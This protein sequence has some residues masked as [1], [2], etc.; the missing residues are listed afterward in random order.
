M[1]GAGKRSIKESCCAFIA[2]VIVVTRCLLPSC[3]FYLP[4]LCARPILPLAWT[5]AKGSQLV[6]LPGPTPSF[7]PAPNRGLSETP[8]TDT[9][10]KSGIFKGSP[11]PFYSWKSKCLTLY[12]DLAPDVFTWEYPESCKVPDESELR[13][14][15]LHSLW[16]AFM[17]CLIAT[18]QL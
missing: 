12:H 4:L 1:P 10:A 8:W 9:L 17:C 11:F 7:H 18:A 14:Y 3:L 16:A 2:A 13:Q 5:I 15:H 6:F